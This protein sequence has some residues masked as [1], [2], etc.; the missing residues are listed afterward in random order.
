M[1]KN[2]IYEDIILM[3]HIYIYLAF[4]NRAMIILLVL[5]FELYNHSLVNRVK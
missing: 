2:L 1:N 5:K 4:G 3:K